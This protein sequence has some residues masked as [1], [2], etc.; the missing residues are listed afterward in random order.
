MPRKNKETEPASGNAG[1]DRVNALI[2][3]E[4]NGGD[5]PRPY[6]SKQDV[7]EALG[8]KRLGAPRAIK[9]KDGKTVAEKIIIQPPAT[10]VRELYLK[11]D[12]P[13]ITNAWSW[14]VIQGMLRKHMQLEEKAARASKKPTT[15]D[16]VVRDAKNPYDIFVNSLYQHPLGGY[17]FP[18][19][20]IK[21]AL[22]Q[23]CSF[24]D[25]V[26]PK[27]VNGAVRVNGELSQILGQPRARFDMVTVTDK[28]G[29][30]NPDTRF[31]SEFSEWAIK[32]NISFTSSIIELEHI[33]NLFQWAGASVGIGEWRMEKSGNNGSFHVASEAEVKE[34]TKRL[35]PFDRSKMNEEISGVPEILERFHVFEEDEDAAA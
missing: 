8:K 28:Y 17:G 24:T 16:G 26:S 9:S 33:M 30:E 12:Q 31:R 7:N 25:G 4:T 18:S 1:L 5:G 10:E 2:D 32:V 11:G 29:K 14:K 22:V 6:A 15:K 20:G 35:K 34:I 27:F 13:L 19:N 23:A 21:K 3:H